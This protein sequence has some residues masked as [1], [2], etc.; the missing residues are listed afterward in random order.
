MRQLQRL[1]AALGEAYRQL[2]AVGAEWQLQHGSW[3]RLATAAGRG[4]QHQPA[5]AAGLVSSVTD[6]PALEAPGE[7]AAARRRPVGTLERAAV[8]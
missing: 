7:V 3:S 2:A 4:T 1:R 8:G 5:A 6:Q